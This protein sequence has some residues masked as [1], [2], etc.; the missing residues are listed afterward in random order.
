M[1]LINSTTNCGSVNYELQFLYFLFLIRRFFHI[2]EILD[3]EGPRCFQHGV[4]VGANG[5][6]LGTLVLVA[7]IYVLIR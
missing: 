1:N 5:G 7:Y 3:D 6:S 4:M 2:T